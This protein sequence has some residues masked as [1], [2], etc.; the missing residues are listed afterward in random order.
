MKNPNGFNTSIV[1]FRKIPVIR[2]DGEAIRIPVELLDDNRPLKRSAG[3]IVRIA[4]T[5]DG[6]YAWR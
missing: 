4:V 6:F 3:Q 1:T 5:S 2:L